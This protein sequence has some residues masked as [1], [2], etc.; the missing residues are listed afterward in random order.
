MNGVVDDV[1]LLL[2]VSPGEY[3]AYNPFVGIS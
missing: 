1:R 3:A 2:D